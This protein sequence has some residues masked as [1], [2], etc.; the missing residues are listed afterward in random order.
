MAAVSWQSQG[1]LTQTSLVGDFLPAS[2]DSPSGRLLEFHLGLLALSKLRSLIE[3]FETLV[4]G[5]YCNPGILVSIQRAPQTPP[6]IAKSY[7]KWAVVGPTSL[8]RSL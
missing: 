3:S 8:A 7:K 2:S 4:Q 5:L 6:D 1:W